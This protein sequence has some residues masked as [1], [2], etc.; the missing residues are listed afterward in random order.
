MKR[1][2]LIGAA[3]ALL[4]FPA[5]AQPA[6]PANNELTSAESLLTEANHRIILLNAQVLS[7]QGQLVAAKDE[8]AKAKADEHPKPEEHKKP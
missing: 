3:L 6:P 1:I 5:F 8:L 4:S 2:V 7:L